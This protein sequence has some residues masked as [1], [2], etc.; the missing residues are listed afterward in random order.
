VRAS[1]TDDLFLFGHF[2]VD[3]EGWLKRLRV[4]SLWEIDRV[5]KEGS[6]LEAC[7]PT[8]A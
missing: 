8:G 5:G 6:L 4:R 1:D 3:G 7:L 2:R